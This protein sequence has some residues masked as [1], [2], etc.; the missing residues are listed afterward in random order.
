MTSKGKVSEVLIIYERKNRELETALLLQKKFIA[1]GM[2]CRVT[3][4]YWGTDFKFFGRG[5]DVLVVPHLYNDR[6]VSRVIARYGRPRFII[7]LQYE[8]VLSDK[9]EK[10]GH[11]NPSGQAKNAIH[12][13]WGVRTKQRLEE[14]GVRERNLLMTGAPQLDLLSMVDS[15]LC[16]KLKGELGRK[17][18]VNAQLNWV[19]FLSSFTYADIASDRLRMNEAVADARLGDFVDIHTGSRNEIVSWLSSALDQYPDRIFIYRPHP[20]ELSVS[21][22]Q[23]LAHKYENLK[24][25]SFGSA[26]QWIMASDVILSWY[27]TTVVESHYLRKMYRILRPVELPSDFDSVLL[28]KAKFTR[29]REVFMADLEDCSRG[30]GLPLSDSDILEYYDNVSGYSASDNI[31]AYV[32]RLIGQHHKQ[33]FDVSLLSLARAKLISLSV[34][35]VFLL[36]SA[37]GKVWGKKYLYRSAFLG[38]WFSEFDNQFCDQSEI[39]DVKRGIASYLRIRNPK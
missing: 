3:Q 25:I 20:D 18:G 9:W 27:S 19:L 7:N 22:V 8:Q 23:A 4:F 13:C 17:F 6:S 28:K 38:R 34:F 15:E 16:A 37:S 35:L 26:K 5:P 39:D 14:F 36:Y 2:N 11:H 10:L 21:V 24:I 33:A 1:A 30:R 31:V 12:V 29:E 32:A